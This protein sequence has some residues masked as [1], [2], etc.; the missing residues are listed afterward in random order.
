MESQEI[1]LQVDVL[2][3]NIA[4]LTELMLV[5]GEYPTT[6]GAVIV[7]LLEQTNRLNVLETR[8]LD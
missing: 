8:C 3:A 7:R 6:R 4:E 1:R 5:L 2:K